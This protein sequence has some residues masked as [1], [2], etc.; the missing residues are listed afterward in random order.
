MENIYYEYKGEI[1]R[2]LKFPTSACNSWIH[3][4]FDYPFLKPQNL[5]AVG[6][7]MPEDYSVRHNRGKVDHP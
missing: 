4:N 3:N 5:N 1:S 6:R 7:V 2:F